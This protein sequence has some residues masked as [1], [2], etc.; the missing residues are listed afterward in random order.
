[1]D[2]GLKTTMSI[3]VSQHTVFKQERPKPLPGE[4]RQDYHRRCHA[5]RQAHRQP[6]KVKRRQPKRQCPTTEAIRWLTG[7]VFRHVYGEKVGDDVFPCMTKEAFVGFYNERRHGKRLPNYKYQDHFDSLATY[8]FFATPNKTAEHV[9][10]MIDIDVLKRKRLGSPEGARKFAVFLRTLFP[11][12][13]VEAS[14][15]G[16]GQHAYLLVHKPGYSAEEVKAALKH[17]ECWLR[18]QAKGFDIEIVE[19]KGTPPVVKYREGGSI[20]AITYGSFAKLPREVNRFSEWASTTTVTV[21]Q[22]L[23]LPMTEEKADDKDHKVQESQRPPCGSISGKNISREELDLMPTWER[24]FRQ[25]RQKGMLH[26]GRWVVTETDFAQAVVLLRFFMENRNPDGSLPQRRVQELWTALHEAGDF[27]RPWNHHRWKAI[28]DWMSE[29]GWLEWQD[30]RYQIGTG[31]GNGQA[32]KWR[33]HEDFVQ[34]LDEFV[35]YNEEG[36]A[37]FVDTRV[38][39]R[40]Q[41]KSLKPVRYWFKQA[42]SADFWLAAEKACENLFAA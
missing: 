26:G 12:L 19:V 29:M 37:S 33:L 2:T 17:L 22:L 6:T 9:L 30:H 38:L 15:G 18:Q 10:A 40:G 23:A 8:Y 25:A 20:E 4:T 41:G 5:F 36:K 31:R 21:K 1:M 11:N 32:C 42:E 24:F 3:V 27:S 16:K 35:L 28:R 34:L 14:T 39:Q 13:Y 7:K